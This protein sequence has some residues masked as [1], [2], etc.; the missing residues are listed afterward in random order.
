M[1]SSLNVGCI[2]LLLSSSWVSF[3]NPMF[4]SDFPSPSEFTP[5]STAPAINP[6]QE[7][8][9]QSKTEAG[10]QDRKQLASM[11]FQNAFKY[12]HSD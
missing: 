4:M 3:A 10:N 5:S 1:P 12:R 11:N 9:A 2:I 8:I 7:L 6:F